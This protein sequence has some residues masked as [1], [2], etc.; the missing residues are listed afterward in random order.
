MSSGPEHAFDHHLQEIGEDHQPEKHERHIV[1]EVGEVTT[2][3]GIDP[4]TLQGAGR[5]SPRIRTQTIVKPTV[6]HAAW[7]V[8]II[9]P[10][11]IVRFWKSMIATERSTTVPTAV[12]EIFLDPTPI[13]RRH[14]RVFSVV[15]KMGSVPR[16]QSLSMG[17]NKLEPVNRH[18]REALLDRVDREGATVGAKIPERLTIGGEVLELRDRILG[19]QG[20]TPSD[21]DAIH[22]LTVALRGARK[23]RHDRLE[24]DEN[25]EYETG[26]RLVEEIIGIDRALIALRSIG[27]SDDIEAAIRRQEV[28]DTERWRHFIKKASTNE[29]DRGLT[30]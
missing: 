17:E 6:E 3:A 27:E 16:T 20:E 8:P 11:T 28:A 23:N 1:P 15:V 30:R 26:E 12:R 18:E 24:S 10:D 22:D 2:G 7:I 4:Q 29:L 19:F 21:E 14:Y 25:L 9:K 5:S 13:T